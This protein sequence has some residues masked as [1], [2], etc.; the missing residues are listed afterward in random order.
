MT[1]PQPSTEA[2][3][4]ADLSSAEKLA[5]W[6]RFTP[7]TPEEASWKRSAIRQFTADAGSK[8]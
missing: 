1:T 3:R 4:F 7:K 2:R 6:Q 8:R 5:H